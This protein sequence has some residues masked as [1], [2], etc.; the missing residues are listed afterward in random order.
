[1]TA[2]T[3]DAVII[4]PARMASQ[5]FP[6]KMLAAETGKPLIQHV[7]EQARHASCATRIVVA[8]DDRRIAEVIDA[9]GGETV[10]TL[11]DHPN[12]TSRLGEAAE[13]LGL[14]D[15]AIVINVQGDEPEIPPEVIDA[16]A[17][18]LHDHPV[19]TVASPFHPDQDPADPNVVKVVIRQDGRALYFS[20]AL[21]PH[22]RNGVVA[23]GPLRHV[24]IY[25]Y[26]R[27]FLRRYL[28]LPPTPLE[29]IEVLEQLR[30]L[31]H[32][33]DIGVALRETHHTG[34]DTPAQYDAFVARWRAA[35]QPA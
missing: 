21:I 6:G 34:I 16:A 28:T 26:R 8:T 22:V 18:A 5:R 7:Y 17:G 13:K 9:I 30:I 23:R 12:G 2:V 20:R 32:G 35:R 25:A 1:M 27:D 15:D 11:P 10:L 3:H 24:G 29:R 19:A 4:I 33:F 31:E 14:P